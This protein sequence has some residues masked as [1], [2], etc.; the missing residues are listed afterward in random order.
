MITSTDLNS[1]S[2]R[3]RYQR[4]NFCARST[5]GAGIIAPPIT[6]RAP[7]DRNHWALA[8]TV[9]MQRSAFGRGDDVGGGAGAPG[10]RNFD[11]ARGAKRFRNP[12]DGFARFRKDIVLEI[13]ARKRDPQTA[14]ILRQ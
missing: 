6:G 5:N 10:F 11:G 3:A 7:P 2:I 13:S 14:D 8:Q 12:G 9:E 4:R 1:S